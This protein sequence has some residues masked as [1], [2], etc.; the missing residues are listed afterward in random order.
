MTI[1]PP[2]HITPPSR[3]VGAAPTRERPTQVI[4]LDAWHLLPWA[5]TRIRAAHPDW[6]PWE[7]EAAAREQVG[8]YV[9]PA[10]RS[11]LQ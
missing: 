5:R 2:T 9:R 1:S 7:W 10:R 4:R 3:H 8:L 11:A 6:A